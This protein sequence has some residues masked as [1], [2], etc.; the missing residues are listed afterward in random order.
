LLTAKKTRVLLINPPFYRFFKQKA[1]YFPKGLGYIAA[2]LEKNGYYV[3]IYNADCEDSPDSFF[4]LKK[5]M[6]SFENYLEKLN[7]SENPIYKEALRVVESER[8]D[9]IGISVST[10]AFKA[11]L[12]LAS[13]I[14]KLKSNVKIV[15]GGIHPTVLPEEVLKTG[16]VD[17]VVR[18]EG[19]YTFLELVEAQEKGKP[20]NGVLGTSTIDLHGHVTHNPAREPI[21]DL[22][23][24]PFPAKHLVLNMEGI[25]NNSTYRI[26]TS[27]G[28]PFGCTFCAS[29]KMWGRKVRSRS[30]KNIIDEIKEV[31]QKYGSTFFCIDDDTFTINPQYIEELCDQL[32]KERLKIKWWCETRTEKITETLATKMKKAG[33]TH[34]AIGIESGDEGVLKKINKQLDKDK[35]LKATTIFKSKGLLVDAFFMFGFPWEQREQLENSLRFMREVKPNYAW[36]AIVIPYPETAMYN[37][38]PNG[39][40]E[41]GEK[42]SWSDFIHA[43]PKMA[44]L[45][46]ENL[47]QAEKTTL[48][49]YAVK[50]F[51]DYNSSVF[52][53]RTNGN[54]LKSAIRLLGKRLKIFKA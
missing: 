42:T 34:V 43:N 17:V 54:K 3:K 40:L 22:N 36:L 7:D 44:Y 45:L 15:F 20:L 6:E 21:Q 5:E 1:S 29:N 11:A 49:E 50:N 4:S 14:K 30:I 51:D 48:L 9:I 12:T 37:E 53:R 19:E 52:L 10:S 16:L 35:V 25:Q 39:I 2:V 41:L 38:C 23:Q 28:C 24:I 32:I 33:C 8:P 46:N 27:R 31:K 13:L 26:I 47:T 18:G